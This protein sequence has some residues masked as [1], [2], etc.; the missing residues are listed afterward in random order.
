M[1]DDTTTNDPKR[2]SHKSPPND[3][4]ET[5]GAPP[6]GDP[7]AN[8]RAKAKADDGHPDPLAQIH[9]AA[10]GG[11]SGLVAALNDLPNIPALDGLRANANA[12]Y[13]RTAPTEELVKALEG[14]PL[15]R[16]NA[17]AL[18]AR[19]AIVARA[20]AGEFRQG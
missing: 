6:P 12:G 13:Y 11:P 7:G 1:A 10:K 9:L 2:R 4:T 17:Q 16:E 8:A 14:L 18:A 3:P 20:K 19:D 15:P 5:A